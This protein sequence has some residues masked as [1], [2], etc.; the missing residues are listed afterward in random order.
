MNDFAFVAILLA[1]FVLAALFVAGCDRIIGGDEQTLAET[2]SADP[3]QEKLA[4]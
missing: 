3:E 2:P 4:A 1:F